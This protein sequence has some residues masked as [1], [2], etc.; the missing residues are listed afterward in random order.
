VQT[1]DEDGKANGEDDL[2]FDVD[3][4]TF[5]AGYDYG[6]NAD[7]NNDGYVE[8]G[9]DGAYDDYDGGGG[10]YDEYDGADY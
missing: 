3:G 4:E 9:G 8:D 5:D 6:H 10:A 2:Q 7:Y 1:E